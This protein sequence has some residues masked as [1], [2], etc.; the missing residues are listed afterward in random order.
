MKGLLGLLNAKVKVWSS[1]L[2]ATNSSPSRLNQLIGS[3]YSSL[4]LIRS[5]YQNMTSSTVNGSPSLQR[6]PLRT[7]KVNVV[8]SADTRYSWATLGSVLRR[9]GDTIVSGSLVMVQPIQSDSSS[10]R[11]CCR[12]PPYV[13]ISST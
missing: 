6:M 2:R 5:S 13:P 12:V 3:A 8:P 1:T 10:E 4:L 7:L 9:S 11:T